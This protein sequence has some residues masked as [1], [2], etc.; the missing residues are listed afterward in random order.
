[1]PMYP[2]S[3]KLNNG[4]NRRDTSRGEYGEPF[5]EVTFNKSDARGADVHGAATSFWIERCSKC[6]ATN[7]CTTML[8]SLVKDQKPIK[9]YKNRKEPFQINGEPTACMNPQL[10]TIVE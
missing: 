1:M 4:E 3:V 8:P 2:L 10:V 9:W 5:L 6:L 7:E